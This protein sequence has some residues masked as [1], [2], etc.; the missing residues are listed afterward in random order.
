MGEFEH[1]TAE[2]RPAPPATVIEAARSLREWC[3][4]D[5]AYALTRRVEPYMWTRPASLVDELT[6]FLDVFDAE[7][8]RPSSGSR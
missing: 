8:R 4:S 6:F 7:R 2:E 3:L 5:M 1:E